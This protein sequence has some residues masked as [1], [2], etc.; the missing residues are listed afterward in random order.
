MKNLIYVGVVILALTGIS[1]GQSKSDTKQPP[2]PK[3]DQKPKFTET[4]PE[5]ERRDQPVDNK[6]LLILKRA[7]EILS[8][9]TKWNRKDDRTC[10]PDD[11]VWSLFCALEKASIEI[12][13]EYQHRRAAMQEVRFAIEDVTNGKEFEHRL[14]DYNNLPSTRFED[15]KKVLK[16]AADKVSARLDEK[17]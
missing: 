9:E 2:N 11:K 17:K 16:M 3:Q 4:S 7:G 13:G 14:M 12:L 10:K 8:D 1:L 6:D 5:L 15:I